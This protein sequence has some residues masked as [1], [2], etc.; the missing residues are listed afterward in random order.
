M[1]PQQTIENNNMDT[2][3][4]ILIASY[5]TIYKKRA[6]C[7]LGII[8]PWRLRMLLIAFKSLKLP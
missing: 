8:Y 4:I 6:Y 3:Q 1:F 7:Y 2:T 5:L